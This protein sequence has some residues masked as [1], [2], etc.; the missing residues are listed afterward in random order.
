MGIACDYHPWCIDIPAEGPPSH[1]TSLYR[2]PHYHGP[3]SCPP[4][5]TIPPSGHG[6]GACHCTK[7]PTLPSCKW[8]LVANTRDFL[9]FDHLSEP[10]IADILWLRKHDWSARRRCAP[11]WIALLYDWSL[12]MIIVSF[13]MLDQC[14]TLGTM[15]GY[16]TPTLICT[17]I[18]E[19]V[20]TVESRI[21]LF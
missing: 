11:Y 12:K 2:D 15:D 19:Q 10:S 18:D 4:V 21:K 17:V 20:N 9:N 5:L 13:S 8:H 6:I 7:T 1:W 3:W 14:L 16:N